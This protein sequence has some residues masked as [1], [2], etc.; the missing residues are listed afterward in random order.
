MT[1][2]PAPDAVP[3][4]VTAGPPKKPK[5]A[6]GRKR[7]LTGELEGLIGF[8]G[9]GWAFAEVATYVR[10]NGT[11]PPREEPNCGRVLQEQ[12]HAIAE[13]LNQVAQ[14]N[15]GVYRFLAGLSK[16]GG[17]GGV[18]LAFFPVARSFNEHH[19]LPA[20][21]RRRTAVAVDQGEWTE[22]VM[23]PDAVAT[24]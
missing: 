18:M 4:S 11:P 6:P 20:V 9:G 10:A 7:S 21:A 24:G 16:T 14:T 17:W 12:A 22:A 1:D 3:K 19:V 15:P 2:E 5:T 13:A 23:D 8:A